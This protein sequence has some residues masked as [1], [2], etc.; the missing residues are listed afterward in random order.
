[1]HYAHCTQRPLSA[2][3]YNELDHKWYTKQT[4]IYILYIKKCKCVSAIQR[5][6]HAITMNN[7]HI[8]RYT[9]QTHH[10]KHSVNP[11][12]RN[13]FRPISYQ[14]FCRA[15]TVT[16][17]CA[18]CHSNESYEQLLLHLYNLQ[19]QTNSENCSHIFLLSFQTELILWLTQW[20]YVTHSKIA[21]VTSVLV[22]CG[23]CCCIFSST[24]ERMSIY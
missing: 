15:K 3:T 9:R 6:Q 24:V 13:F 5:Q 20:N 4:G 1:M 11:T 2:H 17:N 22:R 21:G 23:N 10:R 16:Y 8:T 19:S 7:R 12:H 14:R 18:C